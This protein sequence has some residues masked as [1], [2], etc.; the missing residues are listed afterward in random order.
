[1][2]GI[3]FGRRFKEMRE[4]VWETN[5]KPGT[6]LQA[7]EFFY[8]KG[9]LRTANQTAI[10]RWEKMEVFSQT[11]FDNFDCLIELGVNPDFLRF[12]H[13][14]SWEIKAAPIV[15]ESELIKLRSRLFELT[16]E[17]KKLKED[18]KKLIDL[19]SSSSSQD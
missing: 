16:E 11:V 12:S 1:M 8:K 6:Q 3:H 19:L 17:I 2:S 10:S 15:D 7:A 14:T 18:N 9:K 4:A 13:V 5:G